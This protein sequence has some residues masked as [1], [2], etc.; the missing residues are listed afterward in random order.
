MTIIYIYI[1]LYYIL[2]CLNPAKDRKKLCGGRLF[3]NAVS[4]GS[5]ARK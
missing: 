5:I 3:Y 4:A 1:F 2:T